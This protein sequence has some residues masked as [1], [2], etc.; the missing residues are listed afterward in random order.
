MS[1]DKNARPTDAITRVAFDRSVRFPDA[2]GTELT[3][4][5]AEAH[6]ERCTCEIGAGNAVI[7]RGPKGST[8]VPA[9]R[10]LYV[11]MWSKAKA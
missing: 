8:F 6:L 7:L 4:W 2:H 9:A 11:E 5:S 1:N 3:A 10:V